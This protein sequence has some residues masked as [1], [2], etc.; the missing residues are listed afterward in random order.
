MSA[1]LTVVRGAM[2]VVAAPHTF[3]PLLRSFTT[4]P[5]YS[6]GNLPTPQPFKTTPFQPHQRNIDLAEGRHP[7]R[8]QPRLGALVRTEKAPNFIPNF[9]HRKY[10][11]Y[12]PLLFLYFTGINESPIYVQL[13]YQTLNL[14]MSILWQTLSKFWK[15]IKIWIGK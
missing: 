10:P 2:T 6:G 7:A 11:F 8:Y 9:Q 4:P 13:F 15:I 14:P 12:A 5:P 3:I 1:I